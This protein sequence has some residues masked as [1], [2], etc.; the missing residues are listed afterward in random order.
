MYSI[1]AGE[2]AKKVIG[3]ILQ[4]EL[5]KRMRE[6]KVLRRVVIGTVA[7]DIHDIGKHRSHYVICDWL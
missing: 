5:M 3:E 1:T 7:G 2:I 4:P 6:G